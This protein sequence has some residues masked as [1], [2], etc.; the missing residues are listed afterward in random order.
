[1]ADIQNSPVYKVLGFGEPPEA[2]QHR[3]ESM[4]LTDYENLVGVCAR[5]AFINQVESGR[6]I[7]GW[8][9]QEHAL[10][11]QFERLKL[12]LT[13]TCIDAITGIAFEQFHD[14]LNR[15]YKSKSIQ[16]SETW[17]TAAQELTNSQTSEQTGELL[18][19]H[20]YE[21]YSLDYLN[22]TS[23]RRAIKNF[24]RNSD[25]WLKNW[26]CNLYAI[27]YLEQFSASSPS[28]QWANM[29]EDK[30]S[31]RIAEYLY[32]TRNLYTHTVVGYETLNFAQRSA[33][34]QIPGYLAILIPA[35]SS[36]EKIM[37]VALPVEYGE[38]EVIRLL[39]VW[40]MRK[41]RLKIDDDKSFLENYWEAVR[42]SNG[43]AS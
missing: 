36:S 5:L 18:R 14:W 2:F 24:V 29:S 23:K 30:K 6:K 33:Q 27:D 35:S 7:S 38:A 43:K 4:T 15:E 39:I 28:K 34:N 8:N 11:L 1:M 31:E 16:N 17:Q 22:A 21:I 25:P 13:I 42:S 12:Y 40:W 32:R 37:Q 3:L 19:K 9:I 10:S 20:I 26:L 41:K